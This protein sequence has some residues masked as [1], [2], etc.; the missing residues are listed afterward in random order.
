MDEM[1]DA[2]ASPE[3][4]DSSPAEPGNAEAQSQSWSEIFNSEASDD[5]K[6]ESA[7][8]AKDDAAAEDAEKPDAA[9]ETEKPEDVPW[10]ADKRFQEFMAEKKLLDSVKPLLEP[11][12]EQFGGVEG[13]QAEVARQE[14]AA[15]QAAQEAQAAQDQ[16]AI[17][18]RVTKQIEAGQLPE[19]AYEAAVRH[20]V[21]EARLYRIEMQS[22][23]Q[24]AAQEYPDMDQE[25]VKALASDPAAVKALAQHTHTRIAAL[26]AQH[27]KEIATAGQKAIAEYVA[28]HAERQKAAP[29]QSN[30]GAGPSAPLDRNNM[31]S[32]T[33]ILG[34]GRKV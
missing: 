3:A 26:K 22:A 18:A 2:T 14:A 5:Q 12:L 13:L 1:T 29:A 11:L 16:A 20:Q 19:E 8:V 25:L 33:T 23:V 24:L 7:N 28:T 27:A 31:P 32:W 4:A 9:E 21:A 10:N 15:A 30:D 34:I 17:A 6:A